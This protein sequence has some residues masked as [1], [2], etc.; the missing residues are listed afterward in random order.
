MVAVEP[1]VAAEREGDRLDVVCG[2]GPDAYVVQAVKLNR[3]QTHL[4]QRGLS[5]VR[6]VV[7]LMGEVMQSGQEPSARLTLL[8]VFAG[9]A[10]LSK[11]AE[12]DGWHVLPP[13]DIKLQGLDLSIQEHQELLKDV[14]R[15]QQ[16]DVVTLSP[17]CG[18]WSSWQRMRVRRSELRTLRRQ[19]LPF[20]ELT[21]WIWEW[22]SQHRGLCLLEQPQQSE[23]LNLPVMM[24]RR[25]VFQLIIDQC[26]YG[27]KDRVSGKP[28]K[29]PTAI[30]LNH[31][32][33][34][35]WPNRRCEHQPEEHEQIS[36]SVRVVRDS[37]WRTLRRSELAAEWPRALCLWMLHGM[38]QILMSELPEVHE[39]S[40]P[41]EC[42]SLWTAVP[43]ELEA[44][45]EGQL[46]QQMAQLEMSHGL[47]RFD[48]ITFRGESARLSKKLRSAVAH[49]HVAL[50]H[51][52]SDKLARMMA[53]NGAKPTIL[54]AVKDMQC[55][56]C[57]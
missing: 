51:I 55:Q 22:Q 45:P 26:M 6:G 32:G 27:L 29:K 13:Q 36:G 3:G 2:D 14:I 52:G 37:Q 23:A 53:L 41:E 5:Q 54:Q 11:L 15:E 28:H 44:S 18:P 34:L 48:Y 46:R 42:N 17:A 25:G 39:M 57:L 24:A 40:L 16:P 43:V 49:L 8:E 47:Q 30:Q 31:P 9:C 38:Q 35:N 20:W 19:H 10:R 50:G 56:I 4:L 21:A 12:T 7:K 33:I 1:T